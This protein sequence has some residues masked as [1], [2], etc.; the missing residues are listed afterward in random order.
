LNIYVLL[1]PALFGADIGWFSARV[2]ALCLIAGAL[3]ALYYTVKWIYGAGAA[4]LSIL[5]PVLLFSLTKTSDFLHYSSEQFPI[6]LT[7]V[8]LAAAAYLARGVGSR[9]SRLIACTTA[10]LFLGCPFLAKLQAA[11]I[12]LAVL[13]SLAASMVTSSR[14]S[15]S[16]NAEILA[17]GAGLVVVPSIVLI[18]LCVT[19]GLP[20]AVISYYKMTLVFVAKGAP[21]PPSFFFM[22]VPEYN[23][24]ALASLV[25]I[26][27]GAVVLYSRVRLTRSDLWALG[28]SILLLLAA[29]FAIYHA[30]YP[31]P[32]YLLFSIIPISFCVANVLGLMHRAGFGKGHAVL[33]RSLFA[34]LFLVPIG[35]AAL[36]SENEF[37]PQAIVPMREEVLAI[38]RH[39]KPG[40][41]MV[42]W[43][44]RP[45]YY[46]KTK[47][48][49]ATRDPGILALMA[50]SRYQG[51][52]RERFMSDLR[53]H[54][55][56]VIVDAV[57]PRAFLFSDHATQ[58]IENFPQLAAFVGEHYTQ[59]EEVAGV[60][61]FVANNLR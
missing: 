61:I 53:A 27:C 17:T 56:P 33:A 20:N 40:D 43:A 59:R 6:F 36:T 54:P 39:V 32:H 4:R 2:V 55:P 44:F 8:P 25:V 28:S 23:F 30:H 18:I 7:T 29:L 10:G 22:G 19:G 48:I 42:V 38:A 24:F 11:P 26:L 5:P 46:V 47:T 15:K 50:V 58:G 51:Y 34:A 60:R 49:M 21:V 3:C 13:V 1:L 35:F 16:R 57:A 12:A 31:F 52:F 14:T 41:R 37:S 9:S 45:E